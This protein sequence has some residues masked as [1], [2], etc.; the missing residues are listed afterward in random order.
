MQS[1][2]TGPWT[3]AETGKTLSF[4]LPA[5]APIVVRAEK[6]LGQ[7]V[8]PRRRKLGFL[9]LHEQ[10]T[11]L[12]EKTLFRARPSARCLAFGHRGALPASV[13][14]LAAARPPASQ[15]QLQALRQ[16]RPEAGG[17]PRPASSILSL[18][19]R[20]VRKQSPVDSVC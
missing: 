2:Q 12:G 19:S 13:G 10:E 20:G 7:V 14:P 18:G 1:V 16:Q 5:S 11:A 8:A 3:K 9:C 4:Y 17:A 6:Q 15:L